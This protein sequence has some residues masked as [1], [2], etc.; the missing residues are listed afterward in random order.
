MEYVQR[1]P[2]GMRRQSKERNNEVEE[3]SQKNS[4]ILI[5][6]TTTM[7][8]GK[9]DDCFIARN[10]VRCDKVALR[11]LALAYVLYV[12]SVISEYVMDRKDTHIWDE[13]TNDKTSLFMIMKHKYLFSDIKVI[14]K[15]I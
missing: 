5:N 15:T 8:F 10:G 7:P 3:Y 11:R 1:N 2:M 4:K 13:D 9:V 14:V 12:E 6:I